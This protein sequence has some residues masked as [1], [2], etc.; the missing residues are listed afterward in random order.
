M[1][2]TKEFFIRNCFLAGRPH[3]SKP[4]SSKVFCDRESCSYCYSSGCLGC[5]PGNSTSSL[6]WCLF[7]LH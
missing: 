7:P 1:Q 2:V 5:F 6:C 3:W 4:R